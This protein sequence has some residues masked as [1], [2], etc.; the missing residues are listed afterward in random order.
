M[1]TAERYHDF[2][3]GHR[4]FGHESKC[5]YLHGHNYRVHFTVT[6][7]RLDVVGRVMD[8]ST[9]KERLC[10]WL[11]NNWDHRFLVYDRDPWAEALQQLDD[12][13]VVVPFNPTAENIAS[14]LLRFVGPTQLEGTGITLLKVAVEETRKCSAS[15]VAL[16]MERFG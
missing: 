12:K 13:V 9:I 6:A 3:S 4:V 8:F 16:P 2:S 10:G 11:E 7:Q 14:Y 1:I 15:A 5:A